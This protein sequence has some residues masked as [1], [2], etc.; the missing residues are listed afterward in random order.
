[1]AP[2]ESWLG[3]ASRLLICA[4]GPLQSLPFSA[5]MRAD[6]RYLIEWKPLHTVVS[7]TVYDQL[8]RRTQQRHREPQVVAFGD[9]ADELPSS[10]EEVEQV[11]VAWGERAT[12]HL[13]SAAT[14]SRVK[15]LDRDT[16]I[17]HLACHGL[18]D[19]R[20][21][22]SSA[23]LLA[24]DGDDNGR[25]HAWEVFEQLRLEADLV[26]LSACETALGE[27]IQGEGLIGLTR[28]FQYAGA[29]AVLASLWRVS[30][31]STAVLME[32]FHQALRDGEAPDEALRRAQL[33]L[34]HG[35]HEANGNLSHPYS[36][37]GFQ[38]AG[39]WR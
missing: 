30:D 9:P 28:A 31:R 22:L 3:D 12:V 38:L 27:R 5:L 21:P 7:A 15:Q 33:Q 8:R 36:W 10:R 4:D 2:A 24:P 17:V 14:E 20:F 29:R 23:L 25:L 13:G 35:Q 6:G 11:A 19:H 16:S 32:A 39:D 1:M 18:L 34:L 26:V 37:A